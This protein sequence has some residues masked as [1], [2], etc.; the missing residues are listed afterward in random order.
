MKRAW[1]GLVDSIGDRLQ[2]TMRLVAVASIFAVP[3][4]LAAGAQ[5]Y[6]MTKSAWAGR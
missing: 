5:T 2:K 1:D 3:C 4:G 6:D